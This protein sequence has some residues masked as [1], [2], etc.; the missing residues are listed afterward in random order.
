MKVERL[1]ELYNIL[2]NELWFIIKRMAKFVNLRRSER[3][4]L[5]ERGI[6]YLLKINI[7]I[8][9]KSDKLNF[10]KLGSFKIEKELR[11]IIFKLKLFKE[12]KIYLVFYVALLELALKKILIVK[13]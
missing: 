9:R 12:M 11:P 13:T 2:I 6:V 4:N 8:K 5:R 10:K 3:L 1:R 7:K